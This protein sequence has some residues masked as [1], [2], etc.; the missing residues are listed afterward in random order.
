M[1]ITTGYRSIL[2]HPLI[3]SAFQYVMGAEQGYLNF[4]KDY[5][6]PFDG[7]VILDIGCGPGDIVSYLPEVNYWGFDISEA[8]ILK[9]REKY[10]DKAKFECKYLT[11]KDLETLP[12]F[13]MVI[14]TGVLHH[15]NDNV[16]LDFLK[17][18]FSALKDGGRLITIDPC[19]TAKQNPIARFLISKDRGQNV[20]DEAGYR[21]L[22]SQIF[23]DVKLDVKHKAWI[24]Y[25][26]CFIECTK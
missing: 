26:H 10:G 25:T 9:A 5:I 23:D 19:L 16:V 22:A 4:V 6:R 14:A 15:M 21:D 24:P 1:Q 7:C 12:K 13:D 3:Y 20:R 2:S 8:Y 17:L 18:A 11:I